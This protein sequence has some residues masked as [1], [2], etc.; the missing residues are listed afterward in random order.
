MHNANGDNCRAWITEPVTFDISL[1]GDS[2]WDAGYD[3]LYV[4]AGDAQILWEL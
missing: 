4:L 3:E 2:S 1:L